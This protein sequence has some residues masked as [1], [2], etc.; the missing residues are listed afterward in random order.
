MPVWSRSG[1]ELFFVD[2]DGAMVAVSVSTGS[3]FQVLDQTELFE[4]EPSIF[5][6]ASNTLF[7]T[8]VNDQRFL[9][10]RPVQREDDPRSQEMV[11]VNNF[12]TELRGLL[13][14]R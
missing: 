13:P 11:L 5:T 8:D 7:S 9:M 2:Y 3:T 14:N 10:A 12:L 4:L 6:G 1:T